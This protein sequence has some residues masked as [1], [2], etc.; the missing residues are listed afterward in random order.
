[1][2]NSVTDTNL[3][4]TIDT[5]V[6][7]FGQPLDLWIHEAGEWH[8]AVHADE[9]VLPSIKDSPQWLP[10]SPHPRIEP[11]VEEIA[12]GVF[13]FCSSIHLPAQ[14]SDDVGHSVVVSGTVR[15]NSCDLLSS[16]LR[17][18]RERS[19]LKEE[20]DSHQVGLI[21][22]LEQISKDFE[23]LNWLKR[24]SEQ[25]E[26]GDVYDPLFDLGKRILPE[27]L[28]LIQAEGMVLVNAASMR[29]AQDG[30]QPNAG[31]SALW[32]GETLLDDAVCVDLIK[33]LTIFVEGGTPLLI[34]GRESELGRH[35]PRSIRSCV[36]IPVTHRGE[37]YG[38]LFAFNRDVIHVDALAHEQS[39][40]GLIGF[41][42][43]GTA[44]ASLMS[45]A[46]ATLA[47]H[48]HSAALF[49]ERE[50]LLIGII[51]AMI[52]AID[53]KDVYTCGHSDRVATTGRLIAEQLGLSALDSERLF[54]SGLLHDIGKIG[55][56]DSVLH[57]PGKLDE[58][59]F[60]II[61]RHPEI[62][63]SIL[64]HLP[65]LQHVLPGVLHHHEAVDGSG[66]PHGLK[67]DAIPLFGRILAVADAFDAMTSDR[68]YRSGMSVEKAVNILKDGAGTQ[69]D[70]RMVAAFLE[71]LPLIQATTPESG[72]RVKD[73][74]SETNGDSSGQLA[75]SDLIGRAVS[76]LAP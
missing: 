6:D 4:A 58:Q 14:S 32:S 41:K 11:K 20:L 73:L 2:S 12:E 21:P 55:I 31:R 63:F 43:F 18:N 38:W 29:C 51:R 61:K 9:S 30:D 16:L 52:S 27:L 3:K 22:H 46:A 13:R 39:R 67:G 53:A 8:N 28:S 47:T 59:E 75:K 36:L 26:L 66:Y 40:Q 1:M 42:E 69:W 33:Q 60:A 56:P 23:E 64:K 74:L 34:N 44:E 65:Q 72:T 35:L 57:K 49:R 19:R 70:A 71:V 37:C 7:L 50:T 17:M 54:M 15:A 68:P 76:L 5:V 45:S 24:L 10:L 62:G 48:A 25:I